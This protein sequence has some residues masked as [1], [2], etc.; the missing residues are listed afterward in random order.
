MT[1]SS[2][3]DEAQTSE[4]EIPAGF[5]AK[6]VAALEA[7]ELEAVSADVGKYIRLVGI[8]CPHNKISAIGAMLRA[9]GVEQWTTHTASSEEILVD[10][11][12]E[13]AATNAGMADDTFGKVLH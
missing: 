9:T 8:F 10:A 3:V 11:M 7:G 1:D 12:A 6:C 4:G 5:C 2:D 13:L